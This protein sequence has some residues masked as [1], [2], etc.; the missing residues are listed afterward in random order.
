MNYQLRKQKIKVMPISI[1][2]QGPKTPPWQ[3]LESEF[4]EP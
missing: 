4:L 3:C 2:H 1:K